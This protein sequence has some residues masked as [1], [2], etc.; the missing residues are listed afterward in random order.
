MCDGLAVCLLIRVF[1]FFLP[2]KSLITPFTLQTDN[3][4]FTLK[5]PVYFSWTLIILLV[6]TVYWS[7]QPKWSNHFFM[8]RTKALPGAAFWQTVPNLQSCHC[9]LSSLTMPERSFEIFQR[10]NTLM[11]L[12]R[13]IPH[14]IFFRSSFTLSNCVTQRFVLK[15]WI[16]SL[17]AENRLSGC[18]ADKTMH[19]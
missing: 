16:E 18:P 9:C 14:K 12:A 11:R 6:R 13:N 2:L 7:C 5:V 3:S 17:K 8:H 1:F 10:S 15:H 19:F 4:S